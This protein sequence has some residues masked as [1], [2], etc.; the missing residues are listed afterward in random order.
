MARF[1]LVDASFKKA[2]T[3][4]RC[5]HIERWRTG[6]Y[7]FIRDVRQKSRDDSFI[8]YPLLIWV[9]TMRE[10]TPLFICSIWDVMWKLV[11]GHPLYLVVEYK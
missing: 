10:M 11:E 2:T 7:G 8:R 6:T 4:D 5:R 1:G 3:P 9:P